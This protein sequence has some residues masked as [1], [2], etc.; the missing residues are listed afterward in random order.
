ME[1]WVGLAGL[2]AN[3]DCKNFRRFGSGKGA[4]VHIAAWA[5][6]REGFE[7]R[8]Q[9]AVEELDC[10]L[11]ELDDVAP[12]ETRVAPGDFP[13]EFIDI[14]RTA[15]DHPNDTVFGEFYIW[16]RDDSH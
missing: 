14:R 6:S 5:D 13:E 9:G 10:I 15:A 3:P 4:Y 16:H 8:I 11:V 12:L 7:K 2:K 1:L